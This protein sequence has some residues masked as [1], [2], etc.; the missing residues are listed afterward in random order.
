[1]NESSSLNFVSSEQNVA[2]DMDESDRLRDRI[3]Q[4][5]C[6]LRYKQKCLDSAWRRLDQFDAKLRSLDKASPRLLQIALKLGRRARGN[7][8]W[9]DSMRGLVTLP[10]RISEVKTPSFRLMIL[11]TPRSGNTWLNKLTSRAFQL[12]SG[13][14][15]RPWDTD[16]AQMP[17]RIVAQLH[18]RRDEAI[19]DLMKKHAFR[20][21]VIARHPF[22]VM[23]SLLHFA[24]YENVYYNPDFSDDPRMENHV[25]GE[26]PTSRAFLEFA[27]GE[28]IAAVLSISRQW[29]VAEG[30]VRVRYEDLVRDTVGE[31]M[32]IA[33]E[34]GQNLSIEDAEEAVAATSIEKLRPIAKENEHFWKGKPG[35]WKLMIPADIA[36]EI[37]DSHRDLFADLGYDCDPDPELTHRQAD[38]NWYRSIGVV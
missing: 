26:T 22:D 11:S 30:T 23:I 12:E 37:Y 16:W 19:L 8:G 6:E 31:L 20:P 27:K 33:R 34:L 4:L 2:T 5:E 25:V 3:E 17:R 28:K 10:R 14:M 35:H 15:N 7:R 38:L 13:G 29:W 1:M 32:R 9:I 18:W 36:N 21:L 24:M